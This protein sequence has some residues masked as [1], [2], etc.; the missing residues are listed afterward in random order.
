MEMFKAQLSKHCEFGRINRVNEIKA[1]IGLGQ[2]VKEVYVRSF[3]R[4]ENNKQGVYLCFTDT[5]ITIVK[6]E[7]RKT[8]ITMYV[9]TMSELIKAFKGANNIPKFLNKKVNQNQR[10]Y[11][12]NGKTIWR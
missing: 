5:G 6:D 7:M 9:T 1:N 11:I 3:D 12:K 10:S 8:I 2:I 4:I